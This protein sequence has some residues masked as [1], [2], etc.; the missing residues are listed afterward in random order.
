MDWDLDGIKKT[1]SN[2]IYD[3]DRSVSPVI[4]V[5]LMV[6]ITVILAAV[7]AVFTM[8][9]AGDTTDVAPQA[10]FDFDYNPENATVTVTHATG[11]AIAGDQLRFAG[12]AALEKKSYE[13]ITE[14]SGSEIS[15]GSSATVNVTTDETLQIAWEDKTGRDSAILGEFAVPDGKWAKADLP[16]V[17][18][19]NG[20]P[21]SIEYDVTFEGTPSVFVKAVSSRKDFEDCSTEQ[22]TCT[23]TATLNGDVDNKEVTDFRI[24]TGDSTTLYVYNSSKQNHLLY[25]VTQEQNTAKNY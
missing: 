16:V 14:W 17:N 1:V 13:D 11:E 9:F 6:A 3:R 2:S 12:G 15:S 22:G 7:I 4:S 8:G 18:E 10:S 20:N 24:G 21:G 19:G 25:S 5:I 23:H